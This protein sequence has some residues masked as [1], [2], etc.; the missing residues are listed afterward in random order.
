[1]SA[2]TRSSFASSRGQLTAASLAPAGVARTPAGSGRSAGP[3]P[4]FA[5]REVRRGRSPARRDVLV[6]PEEVLRVVPV[7]QRDEACILL[8]AV[9][10]AD[11]LVPGV[12][13]ERQRDAGAPERLDQL[14]PGLHPGELRLGL[15]GRLP[16][17]D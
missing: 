1:M 15:L 5:R 6:Q 3:K 9:R 14:R 16:F 4:G 11:P 10:R 8:V 13:A 17:A 12:G 7:L 2:R